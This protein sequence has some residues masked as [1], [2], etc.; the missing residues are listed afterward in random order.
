MLREYSINMTEIEELQ[1][2]N[3]SLRL[4]Q[5]FDRAKSTIVQGGVVNLVRKHN[6]GLESKFDELST[7]VDLQKFKDSVFKYL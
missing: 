4:E 5:I 6:N 1:M 7:E 3:D 2:I